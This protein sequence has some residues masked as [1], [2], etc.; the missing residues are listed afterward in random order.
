M[1][2]NLVIDRQP[3]WPEVLPMPAPIKSPYRVQP[4]RFTIDSRV[5]L[6]RITNDSRAGDTIGFLVWTIDQDDNVTVVKIYPPCCINEEDEDAI[7][8]VY[9]YDL[10]LD[11]QYL[12]MSDSEGCLIVY[13]L[14]IAGHTPLAQTL[15]YPGHAGPGWMPG[16]ICVKTLSISG[17]GKRLG[18]H[19]NGFFYILD[20]ANYFRIIDQCYSSQGVALMALN[21]DGKKLV[22]CTPPENYVT[23][24]DD[25]AVFEIDFANHNQ[26]RIAEDEASEFPQDDKVKKMQYSPDGQWLAL[27]S[28]QM[29]KL[30]GP[31]HWS[32]GY[33]PVMPQMTPGQ[34]VY[35]DMGEAVCNKLIFSKDSLQLHTLSDFIMYR[36][37]F[38]AERVVSSLF[39]T[40]AL[41]YLGIQT[42]DLSSTGPAGNT[43]QE[44]VWNE[45]G[46][47]LVFI[48]HSHD[49]TISADKKILAYFNYKGQ[50]M[51]T[52]PYSI[53]TDYLST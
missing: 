52:G 36:E 30:I 11:G 4:C 24:V 20:P 38:S 23:M 29:I 15:C 46:G 7:G 43:D 14:G 31:A 12:V 40:N 45:E 13:H 17:D 28:K 47:R 10:S 5:L 48:G 33:T 1:D 50:T 21:Q 3:V 39:G 9:A 37:P 22:F 25:I 16:N 2:F 41:A 32:R 27:L 19:C 34:P 26:Q 53:W 6:A 42:V 18:L 35:E 49:W 44:H 8:F 51:S